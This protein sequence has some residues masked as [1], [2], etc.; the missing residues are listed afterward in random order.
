MR[1]KTLLEK[2]ITYKEG[3]QIRFINILGRWRVKSKDKT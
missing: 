1:L 2:A 3:K